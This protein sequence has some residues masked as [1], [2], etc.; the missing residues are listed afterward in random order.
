MTYIITGSLSFFD[1][2]KSIYDKFLINYLFYIKGII[3]YL[4]ETD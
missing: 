2:V 1:G 4:Y 3:Y